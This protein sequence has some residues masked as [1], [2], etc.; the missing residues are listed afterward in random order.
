LTCRFN[1]VLRGK[2]SIRRISG[3]DMQV[4][5]HYCFLIYDTGK[6]DTA[7]IRGAGLIR[8]FYSIIETFSI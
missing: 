3:V 5:F 6:P 4:D 2:A 1:D 7:G 8:L